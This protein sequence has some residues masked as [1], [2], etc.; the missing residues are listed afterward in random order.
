MKTKAIILGGLALA[1][2]TRTRRL[3]SEKTI[4]RTASRTESKAAN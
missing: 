2:L 3:R 4:N 1:T